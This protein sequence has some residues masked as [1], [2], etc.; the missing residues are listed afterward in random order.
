MTPDAPLVAG[1]ELGG[2]KS[3]AVIARGATI[4]EQARWPTAGP[5]PTLDGISDWI[6]A[7]TGEAGIAALGI[8]SFGP[9]SLDRAAADFGFI[10]ETP[11]PG[12]SRLD[13]RGRLARRFACPIGFDTDVAGAALAEGRWGASVACD[14][15]VYVTIGTGVGAGIV[16]DGKPVHG[17][18][19]PELGHLRI[20]R[21]PNDAFPGNCPFHGDCLEGLV[22]GSA[23]MARAGVP[24]DKVAAGDPLWE[25]VTGD[26]AEL[27]ATL[28]LSL[29]P[30]RIVIGGGVIKNRPAL[31][32]RIR[33]R[34]HELLGGYVA[35]LDE[36]T[37]ARMVVE[38]HLGANAGP[39]GAVALALEALGL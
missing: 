35:D 30:Q 2:T 5:E 12:W 14:V 25:R 19:H 20:R 7:R 9:L 24:A 21:S 18:I 26:L 34:T 17:R 11:K 4:M 16:I 13:V 29:S 28:I 31:L 23:I 39:L 37:L 22:S 3:I 10:T 15:H 1:V 8:A 27:M 38:P 32:P 36:E 33:E 6:I